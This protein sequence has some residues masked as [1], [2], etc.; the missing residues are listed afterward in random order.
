MKNGKSLFVSILSNQRAGRLAGLAPVRHSTPE[1]QPMGYHGVYTNL[2]GRIVNFYNW[3]DPVL[4]YWMTDQGLGKPDGFAKSAL[5]PASFYTFDGVN[6]WH[7]GISPF[8]YLVTD[9]QESLAFISRSRTLP[10]GQSGPATAHGVIQSGV[11]LNAQFGFKDSFP[12]DHSA[13]WVRPIQ[14]TR[15]YFQ[16]VLRSCQIQPAP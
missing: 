4:D 3:Q 7:N 6:G 8:R 13:Q 5:L 15:P 1:W 10:I 14:T 2:T 9:P 16:Q 12:D 11:D